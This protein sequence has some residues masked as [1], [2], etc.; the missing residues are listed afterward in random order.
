MFFCLQRLTFIKFCFK[1][2]LS[3][4]QQIIKR[5]K[6]CAPKKP[7]G[8][9]CLNNFVALYPKSFPPP[10]LDGE[11]I[12]VKFFYQLSGT[13]RLFSPQM[14]VEKIRRMKNVEFAKNLAML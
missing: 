9:F 4:L 14:G 12:S 5:R 11:N 13:L 10:T 8:I 7:G 3:R 6:L 2:S 1:G